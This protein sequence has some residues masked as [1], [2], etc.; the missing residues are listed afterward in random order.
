LL[1]F[2]VLIADDVAGIGSGN[3]ENLV[4]DVV[5]E[6]AAFDTRRAISKASLSFTS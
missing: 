1:V 4:F 5:N 6:F 2:L 3:L